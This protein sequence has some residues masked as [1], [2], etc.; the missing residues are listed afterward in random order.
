MRIKVELLSRYGQN[1]SRA[2]FAITP[3][4]QL[5]WGRELKT[6]ET[7]LGDKPYSAGLFMVRTLCIC[8]MFWSIRTTITTSA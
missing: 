5:K 7:G 2:Y 8:W 1:G 6:I 4:V 3:Y